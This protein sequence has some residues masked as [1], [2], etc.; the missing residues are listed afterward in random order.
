MTIHLSSNVVLLRKTHAINFKFSFPQSKVQADH[1]LG[2]NMVVGSN[3]SFASKYLGKGD[4]TWIVQ[5]TS[6]NEKTVAD[7][8]LGLESRVFLGVDTAQEE[9]ALSEAYWVRLEIPIKIV[10]VI[11]LLAKYTVTAD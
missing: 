11:F 8:R 5:G 10:A 6:L 9:M 1:I 4:E 7:T 3:I 2:L